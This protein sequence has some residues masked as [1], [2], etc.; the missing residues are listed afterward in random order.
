M[1][2]A[3][4]GKKLGTAGLRLKNVFIKAA[5]YEG[6]YEN[7]LPT[8]AL[9]DFHVSMARGGVAMTTVS[10]GAVS[11]GARTFAG[12][13]YIH[14]RSLKELAQLTYEVHRAGGKISMQ[15]THCGY[16]TKNRE[17]PVAPGR[18]RTAP[19]APDRGRAAPLAPSRLF[20]AYGALAG[21]PFSR[22]MT[23]SDMEAVAEDFA[24]AALGVREAGFDA[25]E[26]HMGHGYLLSQFLSPATN[27]RKDEY[28]GSIE[29]R[30]RFPLEVF[31]KVQDRTGRDFPLLVKLNLSDGI[32]NGFTPEDCRAVSV[33]LEKAGCSAIV[34]SGGFTSKTPFY[35]MRGKVPLLGMIGNGSSLAE[36]ITQ[37]LEIRKAVKLPLVYLGGVESRQGIEEILDA[38][39]DFIAI[40]RALIHDPEFLIKIREG[41]IGRSECT[42]CNECVVEMDRNGIRCT[43]NPA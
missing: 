13:M 42:R 29:N 19:L 36:K 7:G 6:M 10:Y 38:G 41:R 8:P 4:R 30:A 22:E 26:I 2:G 25:A 15:L 1:E 23:G 18:K 35:L 34:L 11:P 16:F 32:R 21:L 43:Q 14:E 31:R 37:A 39:F 28:G 40:G 20:N 3:F 9:R 17:L 5:T 33:E 27:R 24:R 12:Q